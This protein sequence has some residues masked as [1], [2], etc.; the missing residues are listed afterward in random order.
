MFLDLG[1]LNPRTVWRVKQGCRGER[2]LVLILII[3]RDLHIF[4][5]CNCWALLNMS[6]ELWGIAS[7]IEKLNPLSMF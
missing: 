5:F 7:N 6:Y 3:D 1:Y 4:L 2:I